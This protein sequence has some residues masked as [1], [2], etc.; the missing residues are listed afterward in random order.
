MVGGFPLRPFLFAIT[1]DIL[2]IINRSFCML[3]TTTPFVEG[4]RI[5]RYGPIVAAEAVMGTNIFRDYFAKVRDM[6][7][8]RSGALQT[9]LEDARRQLLREVQAQAEQADCNAIIGVDIDYGDI[10]GHDK[11]MLMVA[12]QGTAVYIEPIS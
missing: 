12:I 9:A 8:G 3:I 5:R 11:N 10:A 6:V 7:G 2:L 1:P 4:Y